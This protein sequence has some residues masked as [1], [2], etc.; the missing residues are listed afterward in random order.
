MQE[1]QAEHATN[2]KQQRLKTQ[3]QH[4]KNRKIRSKRMI[5]KLTI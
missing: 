1:Q 4:Q 5:Y 2:Q 3:N